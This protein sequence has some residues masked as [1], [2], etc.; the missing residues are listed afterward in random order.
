MSTTENSTQWELLHLEQF[1]EHIPGYKDMDKATLASLAEMGGLQV[2]TLFELA[3][4]NR[5]GWLH[6]SKIGRDL[7]DGSDAK[8]ITCRIHSNGNCYGARI[9]NLHNKRGDI[10]VQVLCPKGH[11]ETEP[12]KFYWF[13]IPYSE[14]AHITTATGNLEIPF[15][16]DGTP[17]KRSL[18][19]KTGLGIWKYAVDNFDRM[20]LSN[21][22]DEELKRMAV[23][24]RFY[25]TQ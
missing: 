23:H 12:Y 20:A 3:I 2:S 8:Y 16:T 1:K 15:D 9:S 13:I 6:E 24:N 5:S 14:Y 10:R 17:N 22:K 4:A 11:T 25:Q 21:S 18:N 7:A 19:K